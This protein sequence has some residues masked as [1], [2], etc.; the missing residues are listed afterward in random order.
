MEIPYFTFN[1]SVCI[2]S[3]LTTSFC[4]YLIFKKPCN[5][6]IYLQYPPSHWT[7]SPPLPFHIQSVIKTFHLPN[8]SWF[9]LHL[10]WSHHPWTGLLPKSPKGS[11]NIYIYCISLE[12]DLCAFTR[13]IFLKCKCDHHSSM[14]KALKMDHGSRIKT[15]PLSEVSNSCS[16]L[17]LHCRLKSLGKFFWKS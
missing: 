14:L 4:I 15:K 1:A 17:H 11:A 3:K 12:S 16:G 5:N 8:N 13:V 9:H 2:G 6:C 7:A 10:P